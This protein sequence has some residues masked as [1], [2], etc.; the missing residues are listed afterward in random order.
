M[1]E[2]GEKEDKLLKTVTDQGDRITT[3][4]E[5]MQEAQAQQMQTMNQFIMVMTE[6]LKNSS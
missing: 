4:I 1:Q 3:V 2:E 6:V 5:K